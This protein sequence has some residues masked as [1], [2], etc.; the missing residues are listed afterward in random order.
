MFSAILPE[1]F[2][3]TLA[4]AAFR[5]FAFLKIKKFYPT[6]SLKPLFDKG[7]KGNK[8]II[9]IFC[10]LRKANNFVPVIKTIKNLF[11]EQS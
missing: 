11:H 6:I 7:S 3:Q 8:K 4:A 10:R 9:K 5:R 2:Y 1:Y